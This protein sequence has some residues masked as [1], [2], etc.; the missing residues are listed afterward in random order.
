M[1]LKGRILVSIVNHDT[2]LA[3]RVWSRLILDPI[4]KKDKEVDKD[5]KDKKRST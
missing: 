1:V 2:S 4:T 3:E 5:K